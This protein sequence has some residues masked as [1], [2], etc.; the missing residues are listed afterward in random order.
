MA[1]ALVGWGCGLPVGVEAGD[2]QAGGTVSVVQAAEAGALWALTNAPAEALAAAKAWEAA[3]ADCPSR[4]DDGDDLV[5]MGG[6]TTGEGVE[7]S[8][9]LRVNRVPDGGSLVFDGWTEVVGGETTSWTGKLS[10]VQTD[11]A[12]NVTAYD[13]A[14]AWALAE[15][16][17]AGGTYPYAAF[18]LDDQ[19]RAL[20]ATGRVGLLIEGVGD[21]GD[22][23]L[24][25]SWAYDGCDA[26]PTSGGATWTAAE[27]AS[28]DAVTASF[29]ALDCGAC[30]PWVGSGGDAG[31]WCE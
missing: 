10:W 14:A 11:G 6:C 1:S 21:P 22:L 19:G 3:A 5:L 23:D 15:G 31:E 18:L 9:T 17:S 26:N 7:L 24:A 28:S 30:V 4:A 2:S 16:G 12:N 13:F 29:D 27:G 25:G 8:G 20:S